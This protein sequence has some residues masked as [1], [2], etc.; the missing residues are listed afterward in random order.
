MTYRPQ[1]FPIIKIRVR[2][3]DRKSQTALLIGKC[4]HCLRS[5]HKLKFAGAPDEREGVPGK[6]AG[7]P[8]EREGAPGEREEAPDG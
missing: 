8:G 1:K 5:P 6:R 2:Q 4:D 3:M 7:A